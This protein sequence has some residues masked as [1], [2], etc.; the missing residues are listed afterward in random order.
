[1]P[2]SRGARRD[3]HAGSG[4]RGGVKTGLVLAHDRRFALRLAQAMDRA[5]L[6]IGDRFKPTCETAENLVVP[7]SGIAAR[8]PSK[9]QT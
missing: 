9:P 1:M 3:A 7:A 4:L 6:G 8:L 5:A 2:G